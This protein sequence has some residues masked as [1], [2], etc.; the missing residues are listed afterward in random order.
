MPQEPI[1]QTTRGFDI[2]FIHSSLDDAGLTANEF[3]VLGHLSRRAGKGDAYPKIESIAKVC[4]IHE[5]TVR[6]CI[7]VLVQRRMIELQ[8]RP[9]RTN[10]YVLTH[11]GK[12][13]INPPETNGGVLKQGGASNG[14]HPPV[15]EGGHPPETKGDEGN[16]RKGHTLKEIQ[17]SALAVY[18]LYPRKVGKP[19]ALHII[20]KKIQQ[21]GFD[22]IRDATASFAAAW[23][24]ASREDMGFCAHPST[25]FFQERFNDSPTTWTRRGADA[26]AATSKIN[27]D[28]LPQR[29]T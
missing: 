17:D 27:G 18:N 8:E 10:L 16:T 15:T 3:R 19:K 25:W 20:A 24:T 4:R 23:S 6:K 28:P 26:P 5:D 7:K 22:L 29:F 21:Y 1:V 14:V 11:P 9:G 12:W 13:I 2:I